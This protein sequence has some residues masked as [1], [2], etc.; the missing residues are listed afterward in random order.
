MQLFKA[1]PRFKTKKKIKS[2]TIELSVRK[3]KVD[4]I[5]E[6]LFAAREVVKLGFAKDAVAMPWGIRVVG[7][8]ANRLDDLKNHAESMGANRWWV[9]YYE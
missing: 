1:I 4:A 8:P 3:N 7:V 2:V 5:S 6:S 9:T